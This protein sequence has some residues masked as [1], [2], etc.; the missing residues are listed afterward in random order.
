LEKETHCVKK[1][2]TAVWF[3]RTVGNY[4]RNAIW[5]QAET[6]MAESR[7]RCPH[8]STGDEKK[9]AEKEANVGEPIR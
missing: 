3:P 8:P 9:G 2:R 1:R 4:A 7:T 6:A 5:D